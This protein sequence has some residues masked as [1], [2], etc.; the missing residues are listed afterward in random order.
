LFYTLT[1]TEGFTLIEV[2]TDGT[3]YILTWHEIDQQRGLNTNLCG[4]WFEIV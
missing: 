1:V 2:N 3:I 4:K